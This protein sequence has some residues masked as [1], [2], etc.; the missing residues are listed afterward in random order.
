[1]STLIL[2]CVE[3]TA[4]GIRTYQT[5]GSGLGCVSSRT[6]TRDP[7]GGCHNVPDKPFNLPI[8]WAKSVTRRKRVSRISSKSFPLPLPAVA[9]SLRRGWYCLGLSAMN[10]GPSKTNGLRRGGLLAT[11]LKCCVR[12]RIDATEEEFCLGISI[13]SV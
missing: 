7:I 11:T 1:M 12:S 4:G 10:G 5:I 13:F 9:G 6:T 8:D 3:S 2:D